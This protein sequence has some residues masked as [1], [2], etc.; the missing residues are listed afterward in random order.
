MPYSN[1]TLEAVQKAFQ[2]KIVQSV[3]IFSEMERVEPS[4]ALTEALAK[5]VPLALA[6]GTE[7]AKSENDYRG[8]PH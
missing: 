4:A 2:L 5:K 6:I 7:K 8:C 1:F 3:G